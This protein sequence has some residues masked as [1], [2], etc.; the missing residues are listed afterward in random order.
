MKNAYAEASAAV[1]G[2]TDVPGTYGMCAANGCCLPGT[3][4]SS[5]QGPKDWHCRLHFGA[6][7]AEWDDITARIHNRRDLFKAALW[8]VNR[9]KGNAVSDKAESR[10]KAMGR[11]ELLTGADGKAHRTAYALGNHMLQV[12]GRECRAPQKNMGVPSA[13]LGTS[14]I[15]TDEEKEYA[16]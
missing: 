9:A 11:A 15:D 6:P 3:M 7:R 14:W 2:E 1:S 12:L 5:T 4:S 13:T 8:L 16:A 10:I